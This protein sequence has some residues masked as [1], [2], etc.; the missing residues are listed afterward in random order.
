M[1]KFKIKLLFLALHLAY[2]RR[3]FFTLTKGRKM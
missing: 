1:K 3:L 2:M